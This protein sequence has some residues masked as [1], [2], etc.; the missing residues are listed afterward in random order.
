MYGAYNP[1]GDGVLVSVDMTIQSFLKPSPGPGLSLSTM[2]AVVEA[3][4]RLHAVSAL[5][6]HKESPEGLEE[7]CPHLQSSFYHYE[8]VHKN[9][10]PRLKFLSHLVRRVPGFHPQH[11]RLESW[12]PGARGERLLQTNDLIG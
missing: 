12:R 5:L 7:Q 2:V 9:L 8:S 3:L 10:S 6:V 11:Q 4:A 1:S